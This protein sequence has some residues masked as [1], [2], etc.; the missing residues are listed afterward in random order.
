[1]FRA[2]YGY[3]ECTAY[4]LDEEGRRVAKY[5]IHIYGTREGQGSMTWTVEPIEQDQG[6]SA[7]LPGFS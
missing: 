1:M 2:S 5:E 6:E 7:D 4:E 3:Q